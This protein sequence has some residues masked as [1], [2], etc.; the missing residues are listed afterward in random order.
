MKLMTDEIRE[1]LEKQ[2]PAHLSE[3]LQRSLKEGEV[4][5]RDLEKELELT[6]SL[7]EQLVQVERQRDEWFDKSKSLSQRE[8]LVAGRET[9][10]AERELTCVKSEAKFAAQG[11]IETIMREMWAQAFKAPEARQMAFSL[12][13][14]ANWTGTNGV[15]VYPN[16][17]LDGKFTDEA[18]PNE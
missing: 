5:K 11:H 14:S 18:A 15:S 9:K 2:L 13:G 8:E 7:R 6:K 12:N 3:T 1:Q 10:V 17:G 4:A 16:V